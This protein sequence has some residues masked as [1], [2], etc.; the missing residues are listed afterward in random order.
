MNAVMPRANG[1][2]IVGC[3]MLMLRPFTPSVARCFVWLGV[4]VQSLQLD[5]LLATRKRTQQLLK[6]LGVVASVCT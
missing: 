6:M 4:V 2:N 5:K 3:Y 1:P